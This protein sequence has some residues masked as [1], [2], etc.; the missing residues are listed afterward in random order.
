MVKFLLK[1]SV[2]LKLKVEPK[3]QD[4]KESINAEN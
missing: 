2:V 4:K 3:V 1:I